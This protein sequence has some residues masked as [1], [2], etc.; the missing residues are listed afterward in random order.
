MPREKLLH[1]YRTPAL[2]DY[3][4]NVLLGQVRQNIDPA[5][6]DIETE[7]CFNIE[8]SAPLDEAGRTLLR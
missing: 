6:N 8:I 4:K 1:L 3:R 5:I 2:S 7:F